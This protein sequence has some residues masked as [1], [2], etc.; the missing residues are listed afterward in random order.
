MG[1]TLSKRARYWLLGGFVCAFGLTAAAFNIGYIENAEFR[2]AARWH[3]VHSSQLALNGHEILLPQNWWERDVYQN[4]MYV[5]AKATKGI[6][7]VQR[8][9]IIIDLRSLKDDANENR[10]INFIQGEADHDPNS[11]MIMVKTAST[12]MDCLLTRIVQ[13]NVQLECFLI[14]TPIVISSVGPVETEKEVESVLST[15]S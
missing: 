6:F 4:E 9:V 10:T 5:L 2:E 15:F 8:T 12:H 3:K 11:S 1:F 7:N 13:G 14:G